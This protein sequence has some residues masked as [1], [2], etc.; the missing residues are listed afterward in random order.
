M[1]LFVSELISL[2]VSLVNPLHIPI[3]LNEIRLLWQFTGKQSDEVLSNCLSPAAQEDSAC[4][5]TY[6]TPRLLLN[7][8]SSH[9]V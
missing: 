8:S 9:K 2:E 3:T 5:T 7:P 6:V 4:V 1:P